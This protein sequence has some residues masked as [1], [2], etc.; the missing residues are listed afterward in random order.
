MQVNNFSIL[1][2]LG[3]VSYIFTDKTGTLTNNEMKFKSACIGTQIVNP[4]E[5]NG[6]SF[7]DEIKEMLRATLHTKEINLKVSS[8]KSHPIHLKS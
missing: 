3:Q 1:E 4:G 8:E 2:D 6:H 7:L 5:D